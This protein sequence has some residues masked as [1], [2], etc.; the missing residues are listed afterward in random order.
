MFFKALKFKQ[1]EWY[2]HFSWIR[3]WAFTFF[4]QSL[5][6]FLALRFLKIGQLILEKMRNVK[7]LKTGREADKLTGRETG[8]R[9][10]GGTDGFRKTD[11][12][13]D[14]RTDRRINDR[15]SEMLI[16]TYFIVYSIVKR[17]RSKLY[18]LRVL[19]LKM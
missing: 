11:K 5:Y 7:R 10:D 18:N 17:I 1:C 2:P 14:R 19:L 12:Q 4:I 16:W 15:L 8:R 13:R 3:N 6:D 9:T